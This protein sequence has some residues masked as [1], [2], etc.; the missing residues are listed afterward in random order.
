MRKLLFFTITLICITKG[1]CSAQLQSTWIKS[2]FYDGG[3]YFSYRSD[4]ISVG[5]SAIVFGPA[6]KFFVLNKDYEDGS[7][8]IYMMDSLGTI[9]NSNL[10]AGQ[11]STTQNTAF[12]LR[13]TPDSGCTILMHHENFS[14]MAFDYRLLKIDKYGILTTIHTWNYPDTVTDAFQLPNGEFVCILNHQIQNLNTGVIY[15]GTSFGTKIFS[16]GDQLYKTISSITRQN[17]DGTIIWSTSI[18]PLN[19]LV[20][21][22]N[23]IYVKSNMIYKVDALSGNILW[24]RITPTFGTFYLT[25]KD[26]G[27]AIISNQSLTV[28]DSSANVITQN[29]FND[30]PRFYYSS[31]V[32]N[33]IYQ[34]LKDGSLVVGGYFPAFTT[35]SNAFKRSSMLIKLD[36]TGKGTLDSTSFYYSGDCD[37]D[38]MIM[39]YDDG[40]YIASAMG[41]SSGKPDINFGS[42]TTKYVFSADWPKRFKNGLNYKSLDANFNGIIDDGDYTISYNNFSGYS[43]HHFD[44]SGVDVSAIARNTFLSQGDSIIVDI[45]LGSVTSPID[46]IYAFSMEYRVACGPSQTDSLIM[47]FKPYLLGDSLSNL[48]L[49]KQFSP[50]YTYGTARAAVSRKDHQNAMIAG[51]TIVTIRGTVSPNYYPGTWDQCLMI[52]IITEGGYTIPVNVISNPINISPLNSQNEI[53][54]N[55]SVSIFPN[56]VSDFLNVISS[57]SEIQSVCLKNI[58]GQ[59]VFKKTVN[60]NNIT[61]DTRIIN[62]GIY[63][64]EYKASGITFRSKVV[65]QR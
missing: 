36:E 3:G 9:I 42:Y 5:P 46:S 6:G 58:S 63:I 55:N 61:I 16:N 7:Q 40:A 14:F 1:F 15:P 17:I 47:D 21:N 19:S 13:S 38:S 49:I 28:C 29:T 43:P 30:N 10:V 56:P 62:A 44:S 22:E 53:N 57:D 27:L 4:G 51:D 41:D 35:Y 31:D 11:T 33:T 50:Q 59:E 24:N 48:Y 32:G 34:F 64:L 37:L 26:D 12:S 60:E 2:L 20:S 65:V 52:H 54:Q 39:L 45:I 25:E 8:T 23:I 18:S